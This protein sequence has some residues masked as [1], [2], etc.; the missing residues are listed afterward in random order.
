MS[1]FHPL[2]VLGA[3]LVDEVKRLNRIKAGEDTE[4]NLQLV[5]HSLAIA[6]LKAIPNPTE[7]QQAL[8]RE[9]LVSR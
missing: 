4:A 6:A 9:A 2:D 5:A 8:L 3:A 7:E 1:G